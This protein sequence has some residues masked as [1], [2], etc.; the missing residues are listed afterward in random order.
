[1]TTIY[2]ADILVK[3]RDMVKVLGV[4]I[5]YIIIFIPHIKV[6]TA[7]GWR[8]LIQLYFLRYKYYEILTLAPNYIV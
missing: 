2:L 8:L 5:D 3:L 7:K 6:S 4:S 1:M